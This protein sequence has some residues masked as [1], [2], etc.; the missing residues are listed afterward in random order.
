MFV[1]Y[2]S[3]ASAIGNPGQSAYSAAN[4]FLDELMT[5]RKLAG[6]CGLSIQ[7]PAISGVG[8]AVPIQ[9][10]V[11]SAAR[12]FSQKNITCLTKS[13]VFSYFFT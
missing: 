4:R 5:E 9:T 10:S 1:C 13:C 12:C 8:M 2:S 6:L 3:I 7:W 11:C